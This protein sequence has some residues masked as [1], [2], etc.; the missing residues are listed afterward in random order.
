MAF[1]E[2]FK[3]Q[4]TRHS[5]RVIRLWEEESAPFLA[6]N[7]LLPLA[8]LTRSESPTGLLSEVADR[9]GR[10]EELDRQRNISAAAEILGG[11]R[12]DKNLIRQLLREEIMKESVIYQDILQKGEKIG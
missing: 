4:N 1:Q 5:Y 2:K 12:F 7:A 8:T 11:L 3:R 9:I 10:I 6:D